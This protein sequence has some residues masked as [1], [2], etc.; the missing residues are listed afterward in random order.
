MSAFISRGVLAV[1]IWLF[2]VGLAQAAPYPAG[3]GVQ[4]RGVDP[5]A[6]ANAGVVSVISGGVDGTYVRI[7]A[8]LASVLDDGDTLRVLPILGKGSLQ[9]LADIMFLKGIDVGIV[10]SDALAYAKRQNL[11]PD[12]DKSIQYIAKLYDEELHVL[13]RKDITRLQDL[14][15]KPV[16]VDV[17]GSGTAM[18]AS[19]LFEA[20]GITVQPTNL[21]QDSALEELK[22]GKIAAVIYVAGKPA[23]LFSSIS[24]GDLHFLPVPMNQALL[25]TY[26]PSQL[27][28]ADY[29]NLIADGSGVDTIAVGSVMAVYD[30]KPGSERYRRVARFVDAFFSKFPAFLKPPRHPKWKEVNLT[31]QVPGWTRF[32]A[33]QEWLVAHGTAEAANNGL[34][35]DFNAFVAQ[36]GGPAS[37]LTDA[38]RAALFQQFLTWESRRR[39]PRQ[40][41]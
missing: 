24:G 18:T 8:D 23:R 12:V 25:Q 31:A 15:G 11:F 28:H 37:G 6:R 20:L 16:N 9:N 34:Q 39:P 40:G 13:A 21:D 33:A 27:T 5:A 2:Q 38:Q 14:S 29:P 10:Q 36:S 30:W 1:L 17:R 22:H 4:P 32:P 35:S 19:L 7:A 41:D 26:L 3:P